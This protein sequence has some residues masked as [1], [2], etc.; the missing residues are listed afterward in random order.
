MENI[1]YQNFYKNYK[2]KFHN[3][4]YTNTYVKY[5]V[6]NLDGSKVAMDN[7]YSNACYS[8][9]T[10]STKISN[11]YSKIETWF[12][13]NKLPYSK[14]KVTE[15]TKEINNLGFPCYLDFE[16]KNSPKTANFTVKFSDFTK[17]LHLNCTL[18]LIRCLWEPGIN[19]V[20]DIYFQLLEKYENPPDLNERFILLQQAHNIINYT[21]DITGYSN[22]NHMITCYDNGVKDGFITLE[23]YKNR[24]KES[25]GIDE[26]VYRGV[27]N[28]WKR[29]N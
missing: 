9:V 1:D 12:D 29:N 22:T 6:F 11:F 10:Y 4:R 15:W 17:K 18:Q 27:H 3:G 19:H 8:A 25:V 24:L 13:L 2:S 5:K 14:T 26:V 20:P 23:E 21:K 7:S 16:N 28:L